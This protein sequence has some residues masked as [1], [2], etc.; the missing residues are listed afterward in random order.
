[1][2]KIPLRVHLGQ[3]VD[4][5]GNFANGTLRKSIFLKRGVMRALMTG[6]FRSFSH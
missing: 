1:M 3:Y 6:L 2:D 4:E 5:T